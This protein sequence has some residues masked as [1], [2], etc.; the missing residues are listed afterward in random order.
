MKHIVVFKAIKIHYEKKKIK[1]GYACILDGD[2][3]N[4]KYKNKNRQ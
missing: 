2:M 3:R 4:K 1:T